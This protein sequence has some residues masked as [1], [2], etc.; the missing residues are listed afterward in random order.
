MPRG[1]FRQYAA[2]ALGGAVGGTLYKKY[3]MPKR[4]YAGS[5]P[6]GKRVMTS[7]QSAQ[8]A[9]G[10]NPFTRKRRRRRANTRT[11]GFM[12]IELKFLDTAWN[13]VV[14]NSS[15]NAANGELHPSTGCTTAISV[16]AQGDGESQ[17]DGRVYTLKSVY[18]SWIVTTSE[19]QNQADAS[20]SS[21]YWFALVLDKQANGAT[22][23]SE[24]VFVNPSTDSRAMLPY[25]L[26]NLQN[27]KRFRVLDS[28]YVPAPMMY[29]ITDGP[30]TGSLAAQQTPTFTLSW[31]GNIIVDCIGTTASSASV[32]NNLIHLVG[33]AGDTNLAPSISG[34]ARTRYVG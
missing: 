12:G 14:M 19:L 26:R 25:A 27:Q 22:I 31:K 8:L 13:S 21:G 30:N 17:R 3:K 6:S 10:Y 34:K 24:N 9:R 18:G 29:S 7:F 23:V 15:A 28:V 16:P 1:K 20:D 4:R 2:Y 33:Y 11:G 32:S 5:G